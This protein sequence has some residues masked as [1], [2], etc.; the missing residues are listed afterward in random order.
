MDAAEDDDVRAGARGLLREAEGVAHE[1]GHVLNLRDLVVVREDD[2]VELAFEG[3]NLAGERL[4]LGG[5]AWTPQAGQR[6]VGAAGLGFGQINH[7]GAR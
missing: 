4:G 5:R 7:A 6:E 2:G 3:E 1:V